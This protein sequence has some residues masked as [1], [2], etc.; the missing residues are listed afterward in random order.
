MDN[1]V[2]HAAPEEMKV[3][4]EPSK[5]LTNPL[6]VELQQAKV[7]L[8]MHN[9]TLRQS[10]QIQALEEQARA[11]AQKSTTLQEQTSALEVRIREQITSN[12]A[13][14]QTFKAQNIL[15]KNPNR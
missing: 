12:A 1:T 10:Q 13:M 2:V 14:A 7:E 8:E 3:L 9:F 6:A 15:R 5:D 4:N 11:A